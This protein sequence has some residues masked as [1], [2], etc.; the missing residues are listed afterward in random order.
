MWDV[1]L[2]PWVF[3]GQGGGKGE[4]I[5]V[6]GQGRQEKPPAPEAKG[7]DLGATK[8]KQGQQLGGASHAEAGA[9]PGRS[10]QRSS[11]CASSGGL[12]ELSHVEGQEGWW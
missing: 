3:R 10:I 6:L 2:T 1:F 4:A 11:G 7:S 5:L 8:P 9:R 12:E